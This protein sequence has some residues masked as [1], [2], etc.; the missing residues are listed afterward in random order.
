MLDHRL[1]LLGS[2][3]VQVEDDKRARQNILQVLP[4]VGLRNYAFQPQ[5]FDTFGTGVF[6]FCLQG[7]KYPVLLAEDTPEVSAECLPDVALVLVVVDVRWL[8]LLW[9]ALVSADA[10]AI[11]PA[12]IA[13]RESGPL[14]RA[15]ESAGSKLLA[16]RR[17]QV[18]AQTA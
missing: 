11:A 8:W 3:A 17:L 12:L 1:Y 10:R 14:A 2:G 18:G 16:Y 7:A 4:M 15:R 9:R 13:H 5:L 6:T